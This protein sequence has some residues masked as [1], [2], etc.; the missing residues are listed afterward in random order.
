MSFFGRTI[1]GGLLGG[2]LTG[3]LGGVAAGAAAGGVGGWAGGK[4]LANRGGISGLA[5]KGLGY[6]MGLARRGSQMGAAGYYG[7]ALGK[8]VGGGLFQASNALGMGMGTA[9]NWIGNNAALTNKVGGVALGAMG[10]AA[11]AHIGSSV[12]RSNRGY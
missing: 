11:S 9:K 3:D 4:M 10:I 1:A 8:T 6:G 7:G 12:L 5:S 2:A